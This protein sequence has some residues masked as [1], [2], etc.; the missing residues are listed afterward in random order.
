MEIY[1]RKLRIAFEG[2]AMKLLR[3]AELNYGIKDYVTFL[4]G[5]KVH[6]SFLRGP[7]KLIEQ[8][9]ANNYY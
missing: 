9:Q 1:I 4:L 8:C 6:G 2:V 3:G 7:K 5:R